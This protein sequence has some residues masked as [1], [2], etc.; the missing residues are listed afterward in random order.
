MT[1]A[2][3]TRW[4]QALCQQS[5]GVQRRDHCLHGRGWELGIP[6]EPATAL[7][8]GAKGKDSAGPSESNLHPPCHW[9]PWGQG[10]GWGLVPGTVPRQ[11]QGGVS[12]SF[13]GQRKE[14]SQAAHRAAS[15]GCGAPGHHQH[16]LG[17]QQ[18]VHAALPVLP[19]PHCTPG[20]SLSPPCG[21][22]GS[23]LALLHPHLVPKAVLLPCWRASSSFISRSWVSSAREIQ[24]D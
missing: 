2:G 10:T 6:M 9:L 17:C 13:Q 14:N 7:R 19:S 18:A 22:G 5:A 8:E 21:P 11:C 20:K 4:H 15:A 23:P 24:Q 3:D 16:L 12:V 1:R